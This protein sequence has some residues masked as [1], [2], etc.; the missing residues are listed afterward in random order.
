M[1][2]SER[3]DVPQSLKTPRIAPIL[4]SKTPINGC[5]RHNSGAAFRATQTASRA[6]EASK[7]L[8]RHENGHNWINSWPFRSLFGVKWP[9]HAR[10]AQ[11]APSES[12]P[13][14]RPDG[15]VF[16]P[17]L[18]QF[19]RQKGGEGAY[20]GYS[21][22]ASEGASCCAWALASECMSND[23]GTT[24]RSTCEA[25]VAAAAAVIEEGFVTD[26]TR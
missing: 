9:L 23:S 16:G 3:S 13:G 5:L 7:R 19:R 4:V 8:Q 11:R 18:G 24:T 14:K 22:V 6:R 2:S 17:F 21:F 20:P 25:G 12:V 10:K 26:V 15:P 1:G